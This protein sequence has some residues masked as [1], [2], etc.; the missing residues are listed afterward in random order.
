MVRRSSRSRYIH[1]VCALCVCLLYVFVYVRGT[2]V[3]VG[4]EV[5]IL[6]WRRGSAAAMLGVSQAKVAS[7]G[8]KGYQ[9]PTDDRSSQLHLAAKVTVV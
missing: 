8:R 1:T 9:Q 5:E 6:A 3:S 7:T 4:E 2:G